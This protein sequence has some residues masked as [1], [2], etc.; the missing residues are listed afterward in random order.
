MRSNLR[1]LVRSA[2][3]A[4]ADLAHRVEFQH[5]DF[6]AR[7]ERVQNFLGFFIGVFIAKLEGP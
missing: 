1:L 3:N 7:V 6:A 5:H 4:A 2:M